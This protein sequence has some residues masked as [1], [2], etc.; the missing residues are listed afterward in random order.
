MAVTYAPEA[1]SAANADVPSRPP[2]GPRFPSA[3]VGL[4]GLGV[5]VVLVLV[6]GLASCWVSQGTLA[7]G[8]Q[9]DPAAPVR[10]AP[11]REDVAYGPQAGQNLDLY[12]PTGTQ[13]G[14]LL[15]FHSGGWT[16]GSKADVP[17]LILQQVQRGWAVVSVDY[18]LVGTD[19]HGSEVLADVD[20]SIRYVKANRGP[21][22]LDTSTLVA[23]GWSAGG[24][25]A[26]MAAIA[27]GFQVA[28]DLPSALVA[29]SPTV[30]AVVSMA[31]TSDLTTWSKANAVG[32]Q[33]VEGFLGCSVGGD[34]GL[35]T[36]DPLTVDLFS[37]TYRAL[38]ADLLGVKLPPA[39]IANGSDDPL[40]PL[41][42]QGRP[43]SD[44][45]A[46][47]AGDG[48]TYVDV[49]RTNSH[50]VAPQMDSTRF[51]SWLLQVRARTI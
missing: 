15:F 44:R 14:T 27:P 25:L 43:L 36:C 4:L 12:L 6:L 37:P 5:A 32:R 22:G 31:A 49:P 51:E 45:W 35:P 7:L 1:R 11:T 3:R 21:L 24:Q 23:T 42:T 2:H 39:Y 20:R 13:Q 19:V 46:A 50:D 33:S 18:R 30:D 47:A 10:V 26:L 8:N 41:A 9:V 38:L 34:D 28:P 17:A 48:A 40:V 16:G 29:V